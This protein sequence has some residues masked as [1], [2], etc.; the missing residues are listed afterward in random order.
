MK[1][2][3]QIKWIK[4]DLLMIDNI[5]FMHGREATDRKEKVIDIVIIQTAKSKF[6]F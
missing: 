6:R 5:R 4:N 2:G 1:M 3:L